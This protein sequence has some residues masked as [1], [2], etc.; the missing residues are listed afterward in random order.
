MS[1][2]VENWLLKGFGGRRLSFWGPLPP[3]F[4]FGM[5]WQFFVGSES[6]QTHMQCITPVYA[7]HTTRS[8]LHPLFTP[9]LIHTGK[10]GR[11]TSEKVRGALVHKRGRKYQRD[12][13]YLQYI[14]YIKHQSRRHLGFG[15]FNVIWSM[16]CVPQFLRGGGGEGKGQ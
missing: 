14:R 7:R 2:F 4:F 3:R 12:W 6:G 10:G 16:V 8:L 9:V 5:V 15:V 1:A 13:L 11:W